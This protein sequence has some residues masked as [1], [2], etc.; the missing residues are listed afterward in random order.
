MLSLYVRE[1]YWDAVLV[2]ER[3]TLAGFRP[4]QEGRTSCDMEALESWWGLKKE[5]MDYDVVVI[6]GW[7]WISENSGY[8]FLILPVLS[9][10]VDVRG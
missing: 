7:A 5:I 6:P 2:C 4:G 9:D 1:D 3:H 10:E 8:P